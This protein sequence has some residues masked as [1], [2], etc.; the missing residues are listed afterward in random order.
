[1]K[2]IPYT[3]SLSFIASLSSIKKNRLVKEITIYALVID[4]LYFRYLENKH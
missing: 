3:S 2:A 4:F 1:M